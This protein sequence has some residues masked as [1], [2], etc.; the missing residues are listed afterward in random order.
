MPNSSYSENDDRRQ[1]VNKP[2][3]L[4]N[5]GK[6]F[7]ASN[8]TIE[9]VIST[10]HHSKDFIQTRNQYIVERLKL[11]CLFFA[12]SVPLSSLFDFIAFENVQAELLLVNRLILS[13]ALIGL[14][15]LIR[16]SNTVN[17]TRLVL[18][19]SFLFPVL[20]YT[21]TELSLTQTMAYRDIPLSFTLIP[22][23]IVAMLG[24]FP[25]TLIGG[26]ALLS[27]I[28]L[29]LTI[30]EYIQ[31]SGNYAAVIDKLWLLV[32]FGGIS[33]WLQSGQMVMLMKLYRESTIDSLTGLINRRVLIRQIEAISK[34]SN[35]V[36]KSFSIMMFDLDHFKR[37]NDTYGH[38]V[39][40]QVLVKISSLLKWE[41]R[42]SDVIARFG[43]E[44]FL[45][46]MPHLEL[47][48]ATHVAL[49]VADVIRKS[50]VMTDQQQEVTF[51]TSI[52]VTQYIVDEPI[53]K[54]FKRVDDLLYQAKNQG[55]DRVENTPVLEPVELV[56]S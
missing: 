6:S 39:G 12:I 41:L 40:D 13:C 35:A 27:V 48:Q 10:S 43:G 55:R 34:N 18:T 32:L 44:E 25:L 15:Q 56:A 4:L 38:M 33:L 7:F 36:Q 49:R 22:Y 42:N 5:S 1:H 29:P 37:V 11:V 30:L 53:A 23:L 24:L 54:L 26:I 3:K 8:S 46:V 21:A 20:F 2:Q 9:D 14:C 17:M 19:L 16:R 51:T 28:S 45:V 52:G 31:Y 50:S 47:E